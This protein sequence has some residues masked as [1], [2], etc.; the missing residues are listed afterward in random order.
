MDRDYLP[1]AE[2]L[3]LKT[4]LYVSDRD[5][6][7]WVSEFLNGHPRVGS[8]EKRIYIR[9]HITTIEVSFVDKTRWGPRLTEATGTLRGRLNRCSDELC[10]SL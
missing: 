3:E 10:R 8:S 6:A 7:M 2:S 5:F 9:P 1:M 4:C